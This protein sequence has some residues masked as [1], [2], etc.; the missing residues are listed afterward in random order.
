MLQLYQHR[1]AA[2]SSGGGLSPLLLVGPRPVPYPDVHGP[3]LHLRAPGSCRTG[4][5]TG[6]GRVPSWG[7]VGGGF[8][9]RQGGQWRWWLV[10]TWC[11]QCYRPHLL[12]L[13]SLFSQL[14]PL[15]AIPGLCPSVDSV[16]AV[17]VRGSSQ[18]RRV[19]VK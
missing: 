6:V 19:V 18:A 17:A 14:S 12:P 11:R 9:E 2:W 4:L 16:A 8:L 15:F 3:R 1:A 10:L 7:V 13:S 5:L